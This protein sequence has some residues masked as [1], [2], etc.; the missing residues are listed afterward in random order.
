[1]TAGNWCIFLERTSEIK[2]LPLLSDHHSKDCMEFVSVRLRV[3][4][5]AGGGWAAWYPNPYAPS[6]KKNIAASQL[7]KSLE[8]K[9]LKWMSSGVNTHTGK[10]VRA[11]FSQKVRQRGK[12]LNACFIKD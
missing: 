4:E 11:E 1:M 12:T 2:R 10:R 8:D 5:R 3:A 9:H 7:E 6:T